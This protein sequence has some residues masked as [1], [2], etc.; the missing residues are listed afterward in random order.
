MK[1]KFKMIA[2]GIVLTTIVFSCSENESI[3]K[4]SAISR[5]EKGVAIELGKRL[6]NPYSV[7]NMKK[8]LANLRKSEQSAKMAADDFEITATHLYVKFT[9]KN[10]Q[11]LDVL[12]VDSTLVLYDYPLDYEIAVNGDYYRDPTIPEDQPTPQYCAV[13][14]TNPFT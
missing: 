12:M 6:E 11:E 5:E 8:A 13:K 2:L 4:D 3:S 10:E 1:Q 14:V 9:P 7:S